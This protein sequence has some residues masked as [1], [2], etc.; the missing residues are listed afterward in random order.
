MLSRLMLGYITPFQTGNLHRPI[1]ARVFLLSL[2]LTWEKIFKK[3]KN[4]SKGRAHMGLLCRW[5]WTALDGDLES[6]PLPRSSRMDGWESPSSFPSAAGSS[7]EVQVAV[8]T[9]ISWGSCGEVGT[10]GRVSGARCGCGCGCG[11]EVDRRSTG[12]MRSFTE[13]GC[14]DENA[15]DE[16]FSRALGS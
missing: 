3:N 10:R 5:R 12:L 13:E 4:K 16:C 1:G 9:P 6:D 14:S 2:F 11:P 7:P 15:P 8:C